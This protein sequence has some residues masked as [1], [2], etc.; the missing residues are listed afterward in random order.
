MVRISIS[1]SSDL[2]L[3]SSLLF[4]SSLPFLLLLV[5]SASH[6][7][8]SY[9]L[10]G[11]FSCSNHLL[12]LLVS[13][14]ISFSSSSPFLSSF[15][16]FRLL[17]IGLTLGF[18]DVFSCSNH[19]LPPLVSFLGFQVPQLSVTTSASPPPRRSCLLLFLALPF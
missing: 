16:W 13:F 1:I 15:C 17:L 8:Y 4:L 6:W 7:T 9:W 11:V 10:T 5:P 3:S 18:T 14:L 2:I 12:P 19:L